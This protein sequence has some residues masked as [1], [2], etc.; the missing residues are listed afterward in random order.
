MKT[1]LSP[2]R[3]TAALLAGVAG[4]V[5][6]RGGPFAPRFSAHP[7][8]SGQEVIIQGMV[9]ARSTG[10]LVVDDQTINTPAST[11]CEKDGRPVML[12]DIKVG[13]WLKVTVYHDA[14]H[15]QYQAMAI[16]VLAPQD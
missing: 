4:A 12:S 1:L 2:I 8:I 7:V 5:V 10:A 14:A 6:V 13:D 16:E 3:M 15:D 11:P 9:D